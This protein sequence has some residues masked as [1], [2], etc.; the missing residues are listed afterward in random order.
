MYAKNALL[1]FLKVC[2]LVKYL[3][4]VFILIKKCIILLNQIIY[5]CVNYVKDYFKISICKCNG[6]NFWNSNVNLKNFKCNT[7]DTRMKPS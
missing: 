7:H 4:D 1:N 2:M 3:F 5:Y 6:F